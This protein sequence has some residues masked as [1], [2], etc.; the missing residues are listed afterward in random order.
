MTTKQLDDQVLNLPR[1]R[2]IAL[3]EKIAQSLVDDEVLQAWAKIAEERWQAYKRGEIRARPAR[4]VVERLLK[5]KR[6]K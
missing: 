5:K 4:E 1:K 2:R 3:F 6:K